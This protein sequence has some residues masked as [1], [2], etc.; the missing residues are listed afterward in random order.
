[1]DKDLNFKRT[2]S[3]EWLA[4]IMSL[5]NYLELD[6]NL[7]KNFKD[8]NNSEEYIIKVKKIKLDENIISEI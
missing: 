2:K 4:K 1:M 6:K 5:D 3:N 8:N 7:Y